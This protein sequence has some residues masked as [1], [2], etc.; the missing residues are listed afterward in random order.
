MAA[1]DRRYGNALSAQ[2]VRNCSKQNVF[3][4]GVPN[5]PTFFKDRAYQQHSMLANQQVESGRRSHFAVTR[6]NLFSVKTHVG[7]SAG[8]V[9]VRQD[10]ASQFHFTLSARAQRQHSLS[11]PR[12]DQVKPQRTQLSPMRRTRQ[13]LHASADCHV[14]TLSR[15]EVFRRK[16]QKS[17]AMQRT[18]IPARSSFSVH[19]LGRAKCASAFFEPTSTRGLISDQHITPY[20]QGKSYSA[21][22]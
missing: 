8:P 13:S 2:P 5:L 11:K 4:F 3:E 19:G 14:A 9:I 12:Y 21:A 16:S 17:Q 6:P 7:G 22:V 18:G 15:G 20:T 10:K 1:R